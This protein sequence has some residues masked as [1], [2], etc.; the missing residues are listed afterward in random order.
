[1]TTLMWSLAMSIAVLA[2][3]L[4]LAAL[5]IWVER[6]LLSTLQFPPADAELIALL[7]R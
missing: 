3:V 6:R 2:S 7:T 1:M 4:G 5:L